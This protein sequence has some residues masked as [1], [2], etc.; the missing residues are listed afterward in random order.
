MC[1]TDK[2]GFQRKKKDGSPGI[3]KGLRDF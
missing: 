3:A 1:D 2:Y